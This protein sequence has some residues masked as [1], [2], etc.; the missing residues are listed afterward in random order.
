LNAIASTARNSTETT[1]AL[2]GEKTKSP[3]GEVSGLSRTGRQ[4]ETEGEMIR[5]GVQKRWVEEEVSHTTVS[6]VHS[7]LEL[8]IALVFF[9]SRIILLFAFNVK[10]GVLTS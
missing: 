9:L 1:G 7:Q 3:R 2:V 8:F 10:F 6:T 5:G 4:L